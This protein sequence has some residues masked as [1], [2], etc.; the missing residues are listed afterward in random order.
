[1]D[2]PLGSFMELSEDPSVNHTSGPSPEENARAAAWEQEGAEVMRKNGINPDNCHPYVK[3]MYCMLDA[4]PVQ[5]AAE[6]N[7]GVAVQQRQGPQQAEPA[8][9]PHATGADLSHAPE[10]QVTGH[11]SRL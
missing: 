10:K 3:Q 6:E 11:G 9:V 7:Q 1:M 8:A 5:D 2:N 4:Q